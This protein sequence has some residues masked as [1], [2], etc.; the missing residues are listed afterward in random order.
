MR[1]SLNAVLGSLIVLCIAASAAM[2]DKAGAAAP[3]GVVNINTA[4]AAQL[5][6]LPH[7]GAKAAQRVIDYRKGHGPFGSTSDL[8]QVKGFG[9]KTLNRLSPYLAVDGKTTLSSKVQGPRKARALKSTK[10]PTTAAK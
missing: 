5:A 6:L 2:A 1:K 8:M 9:E 7:V 10:R 3:S 4:D